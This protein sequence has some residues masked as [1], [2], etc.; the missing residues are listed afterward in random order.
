MSIQLKDY[1]T[2]VIPAA[3]LDTPKHYRTE[4][5]VNIAANGRL[6]ICGGSGSG[7]TTC[8]MNVVDAMNCWDTVTLIAKTLEEPLYRYWQ[9]RMRDEQVHR[10][11][12]WFHVSSDLASL[13]QVDKYDPRL[14]N[15]VVIDDMLLEGKE[16]LTPLMD[17][18]TRSRKYGIFLVFLSQSYFKTPKYARDNTSYLILLGDLGAREARRICT[19]LASRLADTDKVVE[20]YNNAVRSSND[21]FLFDRMEKQCV[22]MKYRK[23]FG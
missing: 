23:N 7:K 11:L 12:K 1:Y 13:P 15:L 20:I 5:L 16:K 6:L 14:F 3:Y 21:W 10:K 17:F 22:G 8:M 18:Y 4:E 2:D 19:E 9:D